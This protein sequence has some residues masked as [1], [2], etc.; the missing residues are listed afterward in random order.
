MRELSSFVRRPVLLGTLFVA[1]GLFLPVDEV[2]GQVEPSAPVVDDD[3]APQ[4]RFNFKSQSWDQV[5]DYFSRATGMPIVKSVEVPKGTVD[6]FHPTPY[7]LP[8]ALETLNI[9]LQTQNVM[10]RQDDG[11]LVLEALDES[12]RLN[13]PTFVGELPEDVT[14][15]TVV[16]IILP[17][18]NSTAAT[19]AEQLK[20]MVGEYGMLVALPEQNSVLVVETAANIRRLRKIVNELDREDTENSLEQ[21][22]LRHASAKELLPVLETLMSERVVKTVVKNKKPTQVVEDVLPA[23]FRITADER[24]NTVIARGTPRRID[25]LR[26]AIM[27]LDTPKVGSVRQLRTIQLERLTVADA[28][29][30]LDQLFRGLPEDKRPGYVLLDDTNRITISAEP[31]VIDQ[32][33]QFIADLESGGSLGPAAGAETVA[34]LPLSFA[35]PDAATTAIRAVLNPRQLS[36]VKIVPGP[37]ARSLVVAAPAG[38]LEGVRRTLVLVDRPASLDRQ[39][40]YLTVDAVD[41][42]LA[43]ERA[44][45][46]YKAESADEPGAMVEVDFSETDRMLVIEGTTDSLDAFEKTLVAASATIEPSSSIRQF[47]I[48]STDPS[49][50][51]EPLRSLSPAMLKPRDGGPF[52]PPNFEAVDPLG[53]LI[54]EASAD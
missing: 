23:G 22:Q 24:T 54:V 53:L 16:T 4:V 38:D 39:V 48:G 11:R 50:L 17:L 8:R 1:T 7:P 19:V 29:A 3:G 31:G 28:K 49:R 10:V 20:T 41:P 27:M 33:T 51:V 42:T 12:R 37:D 26:N 25:R 40:R 2:I 30:K 14:A 13:V 32:A 44:T 6:Y 35:T 52:I 34:L 43:V 47:A 18:L 46:M 36:V 5:L 15:D 9:L 21:I 45:R